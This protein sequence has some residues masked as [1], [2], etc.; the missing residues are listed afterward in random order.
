MT[1]LIINN[2]QFPIQ[3]VTP[4]ISLGETIISA[5]RRSTKEN[6]LTDAQRI[7]VVVLPANHWG[8][9]SAVLEGSKSQAMTDLLRSSLVRVAS[10]RLKDAL[11]EKPMLAAVEASDY[12]VASLLS[13]S[14]ETATSRGSITFTRAQAEEWFDNKLWPLVQEKYPTEKRKNIGAFLRNRYAVLAA[15]NHGLAEV[16]DAIKLVAL[17][18][19]AIASDSISIE[20]AGRLAHIEKQL[21]AKS[22][23]AT[24]SMDDL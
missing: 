13:W 15:K 9:F 16:A 8:E 14:E 21:D 4:T 17:I 3:T 18:P 7:R 1:A 10:E 22:K 11:E 24:V 6:P 2:S 20:I 12:T 5:N 23:E 19:E